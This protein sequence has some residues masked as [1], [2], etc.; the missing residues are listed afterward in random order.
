[1]GFGFN[2]FVN[3]IGS[4]INS[5]I[6]DVVEY[7][8]SDIIPTI[9]DVSSNVSQVA[10]DVTS[11]IKDN[12]QT[13][14]SKASE[15][16]TDWSSVGKAENIPY[17]YQDIVKKAL[18]AAAGV[19]PLGVVGGPSD[20]LAI[21]AIWTTMFIAIRKKANSNFGTDPSRIAKSVISGFVKYYLACKVATWT[22]F[23]IPGAGIFAGMS[24]S[25][26]CN[27]YFTYNFASIIIELMDTK[28]YY[29]DDD[30]IKE[31]ISLIK[32][33]PTVEEVKEIVCIYGK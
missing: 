16:I 32:K 24:V 6:S 2:K 8:K 12:V 20:A 28:P 1:M 11:S 17:K 26:V 23:L 4:K 18:V 33:T 27:I 9:K 30:I 19:G 3:E 14:S 31:I 5:T 25:A 10:G 7:T 29:S 13:L 15:R 22:F 21:A